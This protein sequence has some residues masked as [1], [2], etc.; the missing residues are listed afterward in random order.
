MFYLHTPYRSDWLRATGY[1]IAIFIAI[2]LFTNFGYSDTIA[3]ERDQMVTLLQRIETLETRIVELSKTMQVFSDFLDE[4]VDALRNPTPASAV[5]AAKTPVP[6]AVPASLF[7]SKLQSPKQIDRPPVGDQQIQVALAKMKAETSE[8]VAQRIYEKL[9][10]TKK[11]GNFIE[12]LKNQVTN[13]FMMPKDERSF[14]SPLSP[15]QFAWAA[16]LVLPSEYPNPKT[17]RELYPNG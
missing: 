13:Y 5:T 11:T 12:S 7:T 6:S 14:A 3:I 15:K 4:I 16:F 9:L 2:F 1:A 17:I 10:T 8:P